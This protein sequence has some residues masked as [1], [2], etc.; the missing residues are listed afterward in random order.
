MKVLW[1]V[2][3]FS[4]NFVLSNKG[5]YDGVDF[6]Q[7]VSSAVIIYKRTRKESQKQTV[8]CT[9]TKIIMINKGKEG[10]IESCNG[11]PMK[12]RRKKESKNEWKVKEGGRP[13]VVKWN[14]NT[15]HLQSGMLLSDI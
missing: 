8:E 14:Q 12:R 6:A 2:L 9:E 5:W 15:E 7:M 3:Y 4:W 1:N 13:V 10:T 11:G